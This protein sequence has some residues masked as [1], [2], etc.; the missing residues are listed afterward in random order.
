MLDLKSYA[1]EFDKTFPDYADDP[2]NGIIKSINGIR[3]LNPSI[4]KT[5]CFSQL[6]ELLEPIILIRNYKAQT[7]FPQIKDLRT[8]IESMAKLA[9]ISKAEPGCK[10]YKEIFAKLIE[11]DGFQLPTVSAFFHFIHPERFPIVDRNVEAACQ[12][13]LPPDTQIRLPQHS[14]KADK[15]YESYLNFI[16]CIREIIKAQRDIKRNRED[17]WPN[18][19][20]DF[21]SIDKA[22][23]VLG[24]GELK[25]RKKP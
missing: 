17:S 6:C 10:G 16:A 24:S 8:V 12:V 14:Q 18:S 25:R 9:D 15:K 22:L 7:P 5:D 3:K 13:L 21:R 1:E 2:Y 23:M 20:D 11:V 19:E 4:V